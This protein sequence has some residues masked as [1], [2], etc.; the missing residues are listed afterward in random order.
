MPRAWSG[1]LKRVALGGLALVA[2]G[3]ALGELGLVLMAGLAGYLTFH[4]AHMHR[5]V[6]WLTSRRREELPETGGVWGE[7]FRT[8]HAR[9]RQSRDRE[10]RLATIVDQFR[11]ASEA[12]PDAAVVLG[13]KGE[14]E[15]LNS[16]ARELL[17]LKPQDVGHPIGDLVRVPEF[18]RYLMGGRYEEPL[19]LPSPGSEGHYLSLR[20]V[21][22]GEDRR[23]L[24]ARDVT[25]LHRLEQIRR[26]FVANVSHELRSP[27]TVI[28]GYVETLADDEE[29]VPKSWRR[30]LEQIEQ[31]TVRMCRIVDDLLQLSRIESNPEAAGMQPVAVGDMLESIRTDARG[32]TGEDLKIHV[33]ADPSVRLAG[34]YNELYSAFSNLVFNAVQYTPVFKSIYLRWYADGGGAHLEVEDEGVGIEPEHI[35]RLTERFYRVDKARSRAVGGTGLGLAIVK[36]VLMRHQA[37]LRISSEPGKG[38]IFACDFPAKRVVRERAALSARA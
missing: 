2:I 22:Y 34:E 13:L 12:T 23:L 6:R 27:L 4:L 25:R 35:P 37:R 36:H 38:S 11:R 3:I 26:D 16:A 5:L 15:W 9:E 21:P 18:A 7:I 17:G 31:Q 20:I 28:R 33:D 30:P 14:I 32:L 10:Q 19:E 8:L 29:A 1:E 24:I